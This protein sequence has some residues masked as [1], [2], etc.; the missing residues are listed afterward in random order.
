VGNN[1]YIKLQVGGG[2]GTSSWIQ[3]KGGGMGCG[4]VRGGLVREWTGK[5]IM[6]E[7]EIL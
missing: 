1:S 5:G 7:D 6:K 3:G 4:A 2:V